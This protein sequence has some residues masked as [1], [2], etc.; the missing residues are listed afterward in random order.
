MQYQPLV[1]RR[2]LPVREIYSVHYFE[3][4]AG[5]SFSG[6]RH[7]FWELLYVDK[8]DIQVTAGDRTCRLRRGQLIFHAPGEFHAFSNLGTAPDLVVVSFRCDSPD[9]A[10]FRGLT[11]E[12]RE[13]ILDGCLMNY[14]A[15]RAN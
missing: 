10:H 7:D 1:P 8:G 12:A 3:Y 2:P 4:T 9:M 15:K 14:Y 11:A 6:E 5:C 13:I